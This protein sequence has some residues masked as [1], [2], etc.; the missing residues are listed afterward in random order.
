MNIHDSVCQSKS[1]AP[2]P[3]PGGGPSSIADSRSSP[4]SSPI[5]CPI[6]FHET[7]HAPWVVF[8]HAA[9]LAWICKGF[10][11]SRL[12]FRRGKPRHKPFHIRT[13]TV[14]TGLLRRGA[15]AEH[16]TTGPLSTSSALILINGHDVVLR[17]LR[18]QNARR[19]VTNPAPYPY[20]ENAP[21]PGLTL[22]ARRLR[23]R[24]SHI[25]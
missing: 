9:Q 12:R 10:E 1:V 19:G 16:Q 20:Q 23:A 25:H 4:M 11:S 13:V 24:P 14:C 21:E 2:I 8:I 15:D 3:S 6:F 5:S 22:L 7:G 18:W 17:S